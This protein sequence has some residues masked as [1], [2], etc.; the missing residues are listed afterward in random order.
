MQD[1]GGIALIRDAPAEEIARGTRA[2]EDCLGPRTSQRTERR[3]KAPYR[4]IS[5]DDERE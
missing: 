5:E 2:I 1:G 4:K 3:T